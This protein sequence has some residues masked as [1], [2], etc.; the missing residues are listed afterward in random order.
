MERFPDHARVLFIGDSITCQGLW[1]AHLY[2]VY[3]RRFPHAD[4]RFFNSGISGG[5]L[6][7][8]LRYI[9]PYNG[10]QFRPTHAVIMLGMNDVG[11]GLY[12]LGEGEEDFADKRLAQRQEAVDAYE[13]GL[14]RLVTL[15]EGWQVSVT[16]VTPTC[17]DESQHPRHLDRVG[18]DAAL[19]YLGE[20]NRRL[21]QERGLQFV[22]L[23]APFRA[24]NAACPLINPDRVHPS[25][26]GHA[27]M[28]RLFLAAQGLVETPRLTDDLTVVEPLLPENEA[29]FRAEQDVRALWNAEW[30]L[31]RD[32]PQ[33][34]PSRIAFVKGYRETAPS[35]FWRNMADAYLR[36]NGDLQGA[37]R[38]E[39]EA[40]EACLRREA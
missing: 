7:S 22:N 14:R 4:I 15:L 20:I 34:V 2:D 9:E 25:P 21:A 5:S 3:L 27:V 36:L 12:Q 11:R 39:E 38:R 26:A 33:D 17:Y 1:I 28:A 40:L 37:L 31:L 6:D 32:K 24:L 16:L 30:L 10:A 35:D 13:Q 29:R 8:A 19:E 23:H 18:C